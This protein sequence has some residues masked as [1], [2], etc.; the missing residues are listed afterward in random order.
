[1]ADFIAAHQA[2]RAIARAL[3]WPLV[4]AVEYPGTSLLLLTA[5]WAWRRR[6]SAV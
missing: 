2:L 3:L 4:T 6:R 1:M 5:A